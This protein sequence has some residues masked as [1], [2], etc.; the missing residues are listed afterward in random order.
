MVAKKQFE[1]A[2]SLNPAELQKKEFEARK[3]LVQAWETQTMTEFAMYLLPVLSRKIDKMSNF[4]ARIWL[5]NCSNCWVSPTV[6]SFP[7]SFVTLARCAGL[8]EGSSSGRL[9]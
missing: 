7:Q 9:R 1:E 8:V 4:L 3:A 5:Q 2:L 6:Q